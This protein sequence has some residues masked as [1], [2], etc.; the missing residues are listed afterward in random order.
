MPASNYR[1]YF[2]KVGFLEWDRHKVRPIIVISKPRSKFD[3]VMAIP[4]STRSELT[5]VDIS[6][7]DWQNAGLR[8]PSVALVHRLAAIVSVDILEEI[9]QLSDADQAAIRKSLRQ[10]FSI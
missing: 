9:G 1:L 4:V 7:Q 3:I 6:L 5:D 10:L 8:E 2:A